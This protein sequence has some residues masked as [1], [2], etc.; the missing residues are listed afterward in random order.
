VGGGSNNVASGLGSTVAGGT[1]NS[2]TNAYATVPGGVVNT[3]GG[4][5]SFAAGDNATA[6]DNNSFVWGDGS[7]AA[8]SQGANSFAI[9]A[10]GGIWLFTGPYPAGIKL[11][12]NGSSWV[13]LSDR[14]AKKNV[15]PVDCQAVL[16]KLA[17]IPVEQ[18]N[19]KWEKDT[20]TPNIGP[21]AQD[22]IHA[23]YPGRDDK[24]ISTLQFDG[25]EL[26]A[27]QGLNEKLEGR[28]QKAE[29]QIAELK[30]ENAE[31][32]ARLEKLERAVA[33]REGGG[34]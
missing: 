10:T 1:G 13:G 11:P 19:Y 32:K 33:E 24:G 25:V 29:G 21:M 22:F 7:R 14:N 18:W 34:K 8:L 4:Y 12:P 2:A 31:L 15:K 28:S 17:R 27:I 26:A 6:S 16:D 9:L 20:D 5:G 23:F 30:A 3:A